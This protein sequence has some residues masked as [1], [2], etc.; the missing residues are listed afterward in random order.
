MNMSSKT[1]NQTQT[2]IRSLKIF[3]RHAMSTFRGQ[4]PNTL[5]AASPVRDGFTKRW[6]KKDVCQ[7]TKTQKVFGLV[8]CV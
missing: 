8:Q 7:T 2:Q 5:L 1:Q 6:Q 3:V 4:Q